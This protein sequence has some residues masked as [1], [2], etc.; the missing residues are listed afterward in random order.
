MALIET[1]V[2]ATLLLRIER[3]R[4]FLHIYTLIL[5]YIYGTI[6]RYN[7]SLDPDRAT[8][9][10]MIS[11]YWPVNP[12]CILIESL[13]GVIRPIIIRIKFALDVIHILLGCLSAHNLLVNFQETV[14][15][16]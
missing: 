14:I 3:R 9:S 8:S 2:N 6:S 13:V 11:S 4:W 7:R 12:P 10:M 15:R 1:T 16:R 5:R